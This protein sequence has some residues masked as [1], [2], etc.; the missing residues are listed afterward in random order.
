MPVRVPSARVIAAVALLVS[1]G[2]ARADD[3]PQ[4]LGPQRDGVWREDGILD[5]LPKDGPKVLWRKPINPGYTGP[6]VAEGRVF[7]MD[8][9]KPNVDPKAPKGAGTPG[10]E[11]VVCLDLATG[12]TVWAHEYECTYKK[13]DRPMGPRATPAV[14][15]DRVYTLGT[16][17]DLRCLD[18]KTGKPIW[19]KSFTKDYGVAPPVWGF[20][21]H[22]LVEKDL[23]IAL[24]GGEG[25]GVVAFDK[26]TGKERWTA[27]TS[28]DVGYSAPV[29]AE[30]GGVRQLIVWL[31]DALAGLDPATGKVYWRHRHP[32]AGVVQAKPTVTIITPKVVGDVVYVSSAY[33]G[34]L[35][36]KLAKDKPTAE[37]AW[38]ENVK[39]K[40]GPATRVL[41][42]GLLARDGHLYGV[43]ADTGEVFCA[44]AATGKVVWTDKGLFGGND[45]LFGTAFWVERKDRVFAFTDAGDLVLL[46]LSPKGYEETGRAHILDPIGADRG[47]KV[48]WSHPAFAGK[49]MIVRNEKEIVCVSLAQ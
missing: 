6:A 19:T 3:W 26:K 5:A 49:K 43:A 46:K 40:G 38:R 37:I 21:A 48:I 28:E 45:A 9:E 32:E 34:M 29:I 25:K 36:V 7:V 41:M 31:S 27:L 17:G 10:S 16:M 22:P 13:V 47:R 15:G 42:T 4:W 23:V 14:D 2:A 1:S 11:R 35:A 33:D 24:V 44:E 8:R 12:D 20:S 18:A 39:K 30:A